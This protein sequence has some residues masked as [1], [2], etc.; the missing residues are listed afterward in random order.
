MTCSNILLRHYSVS[1]LGLWCLGP[2]PQR[3]KVQPAWPFGVLSLC[4]RGERSN[5][6]GPWFFGPRPEV[7]LF[8]A[9]LFAMG[10]QCPRAAWA[11]DAL[12]APY[13]RGARPKKPGPLVS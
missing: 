10:M 6:L 2:L 1:S 5:F 7:V 9:A 12:A 3:C 8:V 13:A 11:P 4:T